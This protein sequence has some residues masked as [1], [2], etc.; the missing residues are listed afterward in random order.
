MGYNESNEL[1]VLNSTLLPELNVTLIE[2]LGRWILESSEMGPTQ[3]D[4]FTEPESDVPLVRL[5]DQAVWHCGTSCCFAGAAVLAVGA[6]PTDTDET[7]VMVETTDG[8][9]RYI[10][11]YAIE[12]LGFTQDE[13]QVLFNM[14]N[15]ASEIIRCL[16]EYAE[17]RGVTLN[18][19]PA[20]LLPP[21]NTDNAD[22]TG[23]AVDND[24]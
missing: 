12:V 16:H 8:D 13:G 15:S 18:L 20:D 17:A 11:D 5:W 24:W 10:R 6:K 23:N 14:Y 21:N 1:P 19:P 2:H 9:R 3:I 22:N 4:G 7:T